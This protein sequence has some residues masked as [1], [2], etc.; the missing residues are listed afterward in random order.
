MH[1]ADE[2]GAA[3]SSDVHLTGVVC[4]TLWRMMRDELKLCSYTLEAVAAHVLHKRVPHVRSDLHYCSR[5]RLLP[6][7]TR[8]SF[9][10]HLQ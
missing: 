1:G 10:F 6:V 5:H 2:W 8:H 4:L 3:T 9:L 7:H